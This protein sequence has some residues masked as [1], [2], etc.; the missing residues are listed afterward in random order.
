MTWMDASFRQDL[1]AGER[2][3]WQGQP[4]PHVI[5]A[6]GDRLLIPL[7]ILW[8]GFAIFWEA[9]VLSD[10]GQ[11]QGA[12]LFFVLWGIPF[13]AFG[14]YFIFGRFFYKAYRKRRTS[15]AVTSRRV[16]ILTMLRRRQLQAAFSDS[17]PAIAK[18]I[19]ADGVGS[20]VFGNV[21][22]VNNMYANTGLEGMGRYKGSAPMAFYD[23]PDAERVYQIVNGQRGVFPARPES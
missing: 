18:S 19:R 23:I 17:I 22:W 3:L 6:P 12:P 14:L 15:Y 11:D 20:L 7:S 16:L 2:I 9:S 10:R 21:S 13:V 5:F 1:L 8:G 4:D